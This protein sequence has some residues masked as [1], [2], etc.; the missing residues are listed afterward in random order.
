MRAYAGRLLQPARVRRAG[1]RARAVGVGGARAAAAL[2]AP[3]P[4][5]LLDA[6]RAYLV[7]LALPRVRT[8]T[9]LFFFSN[10]ICTT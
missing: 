2:E 5:R 6:V 4:H 8:F 7:P 1:G 3:E 10:S 9:L